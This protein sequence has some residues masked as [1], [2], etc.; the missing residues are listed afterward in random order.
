MS[1][2]MNSYKTLSILRYIPVGKYYYQIS[3]VHPH[4]LPFVHFLLCFSIGHFFLN[5]ISSWIWKNPNFAF[6]F[7]IKFCNKSK[8]TFIPMNEMDQLSVVFLCIF[9]VTNDTELFHHV[10]IG[11]LYISCG[12]MF[13]QV[14]CVL[15]NWDI[16]SCFQIISV[17]YII[18]IL[19]FCYIYALQ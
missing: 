4:V 8:H 3:E 6:C 2:M 16:F 1:I 12:E 10:F 13:I 9:L 5:L 17:L 11:L 7:H 15:L 18:Y 19:H 14:I